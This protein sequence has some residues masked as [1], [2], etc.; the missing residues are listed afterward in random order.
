MDDGVDVGR[1]GASFFLSF[2]FGREGNTTPAVAKTS[3]PFFFCFFE[4]DLHSPRRV[5]VSEERDTAGKL[6]HPPQLDMSCKPWLSAASRATVTSPTSSVSSSGL[7]VRR[8]SGSAAAACSAS[9]HRISEARWDRP[10]TTSPGRESGR[11]ERSRPSRAASWIASRRVA[12][13]RFFGQDRNRSPRCRRSCQILLG[14]ARR[15]S[16]RSAWAGQ[17]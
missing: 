5:C 11:A 13:E 12:A 16:R 15:C 3:R 4:G 2:F 9:S 7:M 10:R 6:R 8:R 17:R 14:R 1:C